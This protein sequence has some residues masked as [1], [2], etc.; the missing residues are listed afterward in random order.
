MP[1]TS[2]PHF[3]GGRN[4][5]MKLPSHQFDETV[6][7]YRDTLKLPMLKEEPEICGFDFGGVDLWLDRVPAMSQ[8]ELW[9]ELETPDT[10]AAAAYLADADVVR[11]D[12]VEPLP[13]GFDGLWISSPANIIHLVSGSNKGQNDAS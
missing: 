4:I 9:L 1:S 5:A 3:R 12:E 8:A 11:C 13:E 6:A 2:Q 7:F 10:E